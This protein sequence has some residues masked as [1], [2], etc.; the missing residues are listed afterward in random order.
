MRPCR[1]RAKRRLKEV[2]SR[3]EDFRRWL[4]DTLPTPIFKN[5]CAANQHT[6]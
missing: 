5:I 2:G 1:K 3:A 6:Q 4:A